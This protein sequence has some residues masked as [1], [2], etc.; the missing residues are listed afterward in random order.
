MDYKIVMPQLSDSMEEGKL[1]SWKVK[2]GDRVKV[3]DTIA[4]VESDKAVMEVQSFK[5]GVVKELKIKEG[6]SAPVGSVI[7][8][9]DTDVSSV[10]E[11]PEEQAEAS[12][13]EQVA[14]SNEEEL[15]VKEEAE[16]ATEAS[17]PS[18]NDKTQ[19]T[20]DEKKPST[21]DHRP[22]TPNIVDELFSSTEPIQNPKSNI[23]HPE[24]KA[25]PRTRALAA[26]YGLD[27]E[28]LQRE[29]KL[30]VPAHEEDIRSYIR[31]RYFTPKALEMLEAYH[32][33][34][35]LF[36][37]DHK[38]DEVEV[39]RY[40]EEHEIPLPKPLSPMRRAIIATVE[41]AAKKP[42]YRIADHLDATLM[43]EKESEER[44][45]TV[46]LLKLLA[47]VMMEHE[48][49]RSTLGEN[50]IQVWPGAS[51]ALAMA[52]GEALYM[53]VL[54]DLNRKSVD[55]IAKE[56]A[57]YKAKL[58]K[59]A[60]T[61]EDLK[62]STFALSNLG[63]TGIESLDAMIHADDSGIAAVG[64]TIDNRIA[65]TITFDHRLVDGYAGALFMQTLK[66]LAKDRS[67]FK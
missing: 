56:L 16:Q 66:E 51:I 7:A 17:K 26:K 48:A 63:M 53:P 62:G 29:G 13:S 67:F 38:I 36:T 47:E 19:T 60:F 54:R 46:W 43:L 22:S 23:Q 1:I 14:G 11:E 27:I 12:S 35:D 2:P 6:E 58:K 61:P 55:E 5:E 20:N 28:E 41:A 52:H 32:L 31:R 34:A 49:T 50:G 15:R 65:V 3:G 57:D 33:D 4:E 9:I 64:A 8:V 24:G 40:I 39:R 44:T 42:T 25:C 18:S 37:L 21:I 30:P 10:S 59:G 45:L